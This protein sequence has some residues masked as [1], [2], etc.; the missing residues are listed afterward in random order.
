MKKK[1]ERLR[2][3]RVEWMQKQ[4]ALN[5]EIARLRAR[6]STV[7]RE[8][9]AAKRRL[10][11]RPTRSCVCK[12]VVLQAIRAFHSTDRAVS[13][14]TSEITKTLLDVL[15]TVEGFVP[16]AAVCDVD[17]KTKW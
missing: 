13:Y 14:S 16:L 7:N 11:E 1:E 4:K 17:C 10:E 3:E 5:D 9:D 6:V 2:R 8:L 15:R 12:S